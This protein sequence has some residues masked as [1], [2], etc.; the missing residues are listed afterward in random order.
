MFD[1]N[2]NL[3]FHYFG[4]HPIQVRDVET[5]LK[6]RL[7]NVVLENSQLRKKLLAKAEEFRQY[8][9]NVEQINSQRIHNFK[10]KVIGSKM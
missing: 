7:D 8:K 9:V 6:D 3:L 2:C 4:A 10:E 5:K 1:L